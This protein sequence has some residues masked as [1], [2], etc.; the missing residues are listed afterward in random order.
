MARTIAASSA[1]L[2]IRPPRVGPAADDVAPWRARA[3]EG[4]GG[5]AGRAALPVAPVGARLPRRPRAVSH[6]DCDRRLR[7]W[8]AA[9]LRPTPDPP[10]TGCHRVAGSPGPLGP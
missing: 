10:V 4:H 9:A 3:E 2:A 8:P 5:R 7:L 6:P 1:A